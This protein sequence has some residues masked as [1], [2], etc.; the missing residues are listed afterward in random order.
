MGRAV[1]KALILRGRADSKL[2]WYLIWARRFAAYLSG[3]SL[4]LASRED[5]E[6]FLST[7]SSSP[8]TGAWQVEQATDALTIL[9][10]SVSGQVWARTIPR[11]ARRKKP[12]G[13]R[14]IYITVD[15]APGRRRGGIDGL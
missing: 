6:G 10:G 7:L 13:L 12:I 4:H 9:L 5:A 8:G 1:P 14:A 2:K 11:S 15:G 3:G